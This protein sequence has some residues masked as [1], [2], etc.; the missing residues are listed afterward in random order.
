[1]WYLVVSVG[2]LCFGLCTGPMDTLLFHCFS[3]E[4]FYLQRRDFTTVC[5]FFEFHDGVAWING[6]MLVG[7]TEDS[8]SEIFTKFR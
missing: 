1:M 8:F 6:S 7:L 5:R 2:M 3:R 4:E